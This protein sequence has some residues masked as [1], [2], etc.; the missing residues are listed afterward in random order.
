[1]ALLGLD[2]GSYAAKALLLETTGGKNTLLGLGLC[3]LSFDGALSWEKFNRGTNE[4][5]ALSLK[6]LFKNSGLPQMPVATALSSNLAI[7]EKVLIPHTQAENP[8]SYALK[9]LAGRLP[10]HPNELYRDCEILKTRPHDGLLE[11]IFVAVPKKQVDQHLAATQAA[12]LKMRL[13]DV[14]ALALTNAYEA[15]FAGER[16]NVLL[17]DIGAYKMT[18]VFLDKGIFKKVFSE[19][20]GGQEITE[21]LSRSF[22]VGLSAAEAIKVGSEVV[23]PPGDPSQTVLPVVNKWLEA[24]KWSLA[25]LQKEDPS[26]TLDKILLSGGQSLQEGLAAYVAS[27][28]NVPA[29]LFNPLIGLD[30]DERQFDVDYLAYVGPQMLIS[31]GLALR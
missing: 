6:A 12:N 31:F 25:S 30:F 3:G 2:I 26:F 29:S 9:I 1:M 13:L 17:L 27:E 19:P 16:E 21:A 7:I 18:M 22:R 5:M 24:V 28:L 11:A 10:Y 8:E 4:K 15:T 20:F 23:P 14:E